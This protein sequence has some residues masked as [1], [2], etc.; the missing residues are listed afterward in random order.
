MP[1]K[2]ARAKAALKR[3]S[4]RCGELSGHVN[5]LAVQAKRQPS[6]EIVLFDNSDNSRSVSREQKAKALVLEWKR[7]NFFNSLRLNDLTL[8][9]L[10]L[11]LM[12]LRRIAQ[13]MPFQNNSRKPID[14][15][16][17]YYFSSVVRTKES[18]ARLTGKSRK[19]HEPIL[20]EISAICRWEQS[21]CRNAAETWG[22][23]FPDERKH[24]SVDGNDEDESSMAPN[25]RPY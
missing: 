12:A 14:L 9:D 11:P 10:T 25:K 4:G 17:E 19:L 8:N 1:P 5:T 15:L 21:F 20:Y 23:C 24:L 16:H 3:P 18:T 7:S 22:A 13:N 2:V 6:Q